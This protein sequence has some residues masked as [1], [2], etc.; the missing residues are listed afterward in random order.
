MNNTKDSF[1][2]RVF[3]TY[4][5]LDHY[6]EEWLDEMCSNAYF[7]LARNNQNK[8]YPFCTRVSI[9][10]GIIND[11]FTVSKWSRLRY[12]V[13]IFENDQCMDNWLKEHGEDKISHVIHISG[14]LR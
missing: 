9:D 7:N 5:E 2:A 10:G 14:K 8:Q 6:C 13:I 3:T 4:A 11:I 1:K 12:D